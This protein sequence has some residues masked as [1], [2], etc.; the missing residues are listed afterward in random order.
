MLTNGLGAWIF[1]DSWGSVK[2]WAPSRPLLGW[3]ALILGGC[4][5]VDYFIKGAAPLFAALAT[6]WATLTACLDY[7]SKA[8][9]TLYFQNVAEPLELHGPAARWDRTPDQVGEMK[10]RSMGSGPGGSS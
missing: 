5:L 4:A 3:V 1:Q 10:K 8:G 9:L 6:V 7:F 2:A